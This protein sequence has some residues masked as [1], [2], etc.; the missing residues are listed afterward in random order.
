MNSLLNWN[1]WVKSVEIVSG[2]G[3]WTRATLDTGSDADH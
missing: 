3:D 2:S 1:E